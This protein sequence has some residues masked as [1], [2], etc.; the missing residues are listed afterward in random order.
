MEG[1][2]QLQISTPLC[3]NKD[4][5]NYDWNKLLL[6][7]AESS[8]ACDW[9]LIDAL[10]LAVANVVCRLVVEYDHSNMKCLKGTA[11]YCEVNTGME[12]PPTG[13]TPVTPVRGGHVGWLASSSL[14]FFR[15]LSLAA[16]EHLFSEWMA[17]LRICFHQTSLSDAV[18]SHV[19]MSM[20]KSFR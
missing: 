15:H 1:H 19:A 5:G 12:T 18:V 11:M 13:W 8:L 10:W 17:P 4:Y 6:N 16:L 14:A 3:L 2:C 9:L 20:L 7:R